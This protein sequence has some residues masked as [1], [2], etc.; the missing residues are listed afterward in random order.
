[1]NEIVRMVSQKT[2]MD[3]AKSKQ[4]VDTVLGFLRNKLPAPIASQV[5]NVISGNGGAVGKAMGGMGNVAK[6]VMGGDKNKQR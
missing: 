3:E 4:A 6:N 1:M 2:G 5:E